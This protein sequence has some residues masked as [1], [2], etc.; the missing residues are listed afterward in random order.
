MVASLNDTGS[1][2]QLV[3]SSV[4]NS[5]AVETVSFPA[6]DAGWPINSAFCGLSYEKSQLTGSLFNATN[7]SLIAMFAQIAPG[8]LRIGGNSVD[9]TCWG[10]VSNLPA[11]TPAQVDSLAGFVNAL[12]TNWHVI[13][14]INMVVNSPTNCA[15]EAAY[16][17][18]ALGS[19]LQGFEIGNEPD[20]YH[21]WVSADYTYAHFLP[22]WRA[23]AAGITNA[24]SGWA[25]TNGGSG[26]TL[27]GPASSY[28]T[29]GY[30]MPFATNET[31]IISML[32][33]HYYRNSGAATNATMN[34]LLM[35]DTN[36][37][38]TVSN[39]VAA[40]TAAHLPQGFRMAES[41]S[42]S[43]GGNTNSSQ[44]G[45]ALWT[46]DVMFTIAQNGG[47]GINFHGGGQG[48]SSYTPIADNGSSVVQARPEFYGLK[49]FSLASQGS[50]VPAVLSPSP[51]VNFSAY[52][53]QQSNG[54][55]STI[56]IN[57]ET[58]TGVQVT[59][60]LG[61][62]AAA[63]KMM[64]LTGASLESTNGF[65]LGGAPINPDGSW[66]GKFQ[67]P[68]PV[69]NGQFTVLVLPMS[70]VWLDPL[71]QPIL[72]PF[73][74]FAV[75]AGSSVSV[76]SQASDP[77]F[78]PQTLGFV[79]SAT[80][81]GGGINPA[82]GLISWRPAISQSGSSNLFMVVVTNTSNLAT[83]QTF[84]VG[85]IAPMRPV[86]S[87]PRF[88]SLRFQLTISGNTGPDY[89]VQMA[90]NLAVPLWR[91]VSTVSGPV[92]PFQWTDTN[93]PAASVFYRILL[94]P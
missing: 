6:G 49:L 50:A 20:L 12:P 13:Y 39:L 21:D 11:I 83:T 80:P 71:R 1:L 42:F 32:T 55:V 8:V 67:Q 46:L 25:I 2:L 91:T 40:A 53:I 4:S 5:M 88:S 61:T 90:T 22:Q 65:T 18:T 75:I 82:T 64:S 43:G 73:T 27:T 51:A 28:N 87:Q 15:A 78:P 41:G 33:Q 86:I 70:A 94:G 76:P 19:R 23:L 79:L 16:A 69:T 36:L 85:V 92:P 9:T 37:P 81:T 3:I 63:M 68:I 10:G 7:F 30:T 52:G 62:N 66:A 38:G 24:V 26:W 60:S 56:L 14:G 57:K 54:T 47:Q 48:S 84:R 74:N 31:G 89:A 34:V 58:N 93:L 59:V 45:A 44:F 17:A 35:P 72:S 77:N 29:A